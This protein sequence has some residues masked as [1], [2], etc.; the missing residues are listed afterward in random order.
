LRNAA[1][2]NALARIRGFFAMKE[3]GNSQ[4]LPL[5][6]MLLLSCLQKSTKPVDKVY[7]I[8]GL[9]GESERNSILVDY[10]VPFMSIFQDVL[11]RL[12][13]SSGIDPN[14]NVRMA[15]DY[16][17]S[18]ASDT[19]YPSW[20]PNLHQQTV[21][22]AMGLFL[23]KQL[24]NWSNG[25]PAR[26]SSDKRQLTVDCVKI[27]TVVGFQCPNM[28]VT[29]ASDESTSWDYA[30][31]QYLHAL[32]TFAAKCKAEQLDT[33][34]SLLQEQA[35]LTADDLVLQYM[36]I[37]SSDPITFLD[38]DVFRQVVTRLINDED[39]GKIPSNTLFKYL[40][41][42]VDAEQKQALQKIL[43]GFNFGF[44]A[45]FR[46]RQLIRTEFGLMGNGPMITQVGDIVALLHGFELPM[47]LRQHADGLYTLVGWAA[48][49][50]IL[51]LS[52]F[53]APFDRGEFSI[54]ALTIK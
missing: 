11:L 53:E 22:V 52:E 28:T 27:D 24:G 5:N 15:M 43:V 50:S 31:F 7:A 19:N 44:D 29:A 2:I 46:K 18:D 51:E 16:G 54:T 49:P 26:V 42:S 41:D 38:V 32:S 48:F 12:W 39:S 40:D 14:W 17:T 9:L 8:L 1:F 10:E 13:A 35:Q 33:T 20:L 4:S 25:S 36:K 45:A 21:D 3:E 34:N 37:L 23:G 47:L 6:S 30:S